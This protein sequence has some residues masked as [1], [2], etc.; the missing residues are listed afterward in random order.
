MNGRPRVIVFDSGVGGLT[1]LEQV[2]ALRPDAEY[3]Y[4]AD[5]AAFPYGGMPEEKLVARILDVAGM[6]I[7]RFDPHVFVVA[8]NTASTLA[9][10]HLREAFDVPFV[11][12]VPAIKVAAET[13]ETGIVG[14]LATPATADREYTRELIASFAADC[15]VCLVGAEHLARLAE[16]KLAGRPVS[17]DEMI[18]EVAPA[19]IEDHSGGGGRRTDVVVLACTHYPLLRDEIAAAAPWPVTLIDPASAIARRVTHFIGTS[20]NGDRAAVPDGLA[21]FT[22]S[23]DATPGLARILERYGI[24]TIETDVPVIPA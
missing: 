14:V 6:L 19:F 1:V 22:G 12:T 21:V 8:C 23:G 18:H 17:H 7:G 20:G 11:G 9:L 15:R 10:N 2:H 4:A 16:D 24:G 5:N 13:T 3:I